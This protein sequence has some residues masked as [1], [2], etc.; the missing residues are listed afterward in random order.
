[1]WTQTGTALGALPGFGGSCSVSGMEGLLSEQSKG[2]QFHAK[3]E[4]WTPQLDPALGQLQS[5]ASDP[6]FR[7]RY[8][9]LLL[10]KGFKPTCPATLIR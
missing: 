4:I 7:N 5:T 2:Q 8:K 1:M 9:K 3:P 10:C 6:T